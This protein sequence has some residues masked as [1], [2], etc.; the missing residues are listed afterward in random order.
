MVKKK[1]VKKISKKRII[2]KPARM[3][4]ASKRKINLTLRNLFLFVVMSLIF[5][6]LYS[7]LDNELF[8][9]LFSLLAMIFGFIAVAFLIVLLV[10]LILKSMKK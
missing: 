1:R 3:V 6:A 4:R 8:K 10:F 5:L 2:N 7:I 9:N